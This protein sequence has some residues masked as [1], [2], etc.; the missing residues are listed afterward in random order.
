MS[1]SII[2]R[3]S[4]GAVAVSLLVHT[5]SIDALAI[6][7]RVINDRSNEI[8]LAFPNTTISI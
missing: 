1:Q 3:S 2:P 8:Q 5:D 6:S 7:A 4:W